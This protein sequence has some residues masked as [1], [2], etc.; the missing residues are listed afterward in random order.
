MPQLVN[1]FWGVAVVEGN[2]VKNEKRE[3]ETATYVKI[4]VLHVTVEVLHVTADVK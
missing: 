4:E 2:V 3:D 1:K